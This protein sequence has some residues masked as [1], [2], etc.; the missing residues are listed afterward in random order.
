MVFQEF[1]QEIYPEVIT[2]KDLYYMLKL[3]SQK[4]EK[5]IEILN[6]I[7]VF[8]V[9]DGD[10]GINMHQTFQ[11][12]IRELNNLEF[13]DHCGKIICSAAKGAFFG[14]IGNSGIILA[15]YFRG[16]EQE[17]KNSCTIDGKLF[18]RGLFAAAKYAYQA[19]EKPR[20]GTIL[21]VGRIIAETAD[22]WIKT[23]T[24][25]FE[26]LFI[27]FE[28]AKAALLNTHRILPEANV[29]GVVDAG[30][31]GLVL[32]FDGFIEA[33]VNKYPSSALPLYTIDDDLAPFL[34]LKIDFSLIK[35]EFEVIF[36]ISGLKKPM[37]NLKV[38]LKKEGS[39][40]LIISNDSVSEIK[41]HIH[42]TDP[43]RVISKVKDFVSHIEVDS[44]K[45]LNEQN[46]QLS[47]RIK[48]KNGSE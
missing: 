37:D 6:D 48:M 22:E 18:S 32:M 43:D 21:T 24:N 27:V 35:H 33:M 31:I 40:L 15:E 29:A 45:S 44:I 39:C 30:A 38:E 13:Y 7:N 34:K 1:A 46:Y 5:Y 42:C 28:E 9:P 41:V 47:K 8:P 17:W 19:V 14:S 16:L 36:K 3:A 23:V 4:L 20:E 10:T 11:S 26:L 2:G 25:P 12:I